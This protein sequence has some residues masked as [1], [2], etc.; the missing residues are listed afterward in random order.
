MDY[1]SDVTYETCHPALIP[2]TLL[3]TKPST[4]ILQVLLP[5]PAAHQIEFQLDKCTRHRT[6]CLRASKKEVKPPLH[7]LYTY[8]HK[9]ETKHKMVHCLS[10]L[11][12]PLTEPASHPSPCR[13]AA[14][15]QP[16]CCRRIFDGRP[17]LPLLQRRRFFVRFRL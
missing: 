12:L 14:V 8:I 5:S 10:F 11:N 1:L 13:C 16:T 17:I 15:P 6:L 3:C 2:V 9:H 7:I 4:S